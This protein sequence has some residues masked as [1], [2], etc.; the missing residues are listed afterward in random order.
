MARWNKTPVS[1]ELVKDLCQR[2][3][4]DPVSASI[5]VRRHVTEGADIM[6]FLEN[7]LRFQHCPFM[8]SEME[9][10]VDRILA[11]KE[12]NEKVLIFGDRDV[13]GVSSTTILYECLKDMGM[14]VQWR[15]PTGDQVYGLTKEAGDDF[16]KKGGTLIIRVASGITSADADGYE[17]GKKTAGKMNY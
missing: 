6:Y 9:D 3:K 2:F 4:I 16:G 14:D 12:E 15:I 1:A 8:F 13:D 5:M 11:A 7:D 10:A 17:A